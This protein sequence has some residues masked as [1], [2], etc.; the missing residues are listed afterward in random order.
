[1]MRLF[2]KLIISSSIASKR[3]RSKMGILFCGSLA[4]AVH[5]RPPQ[6]GF[7]KG[8]GIDHIQACTIQTMQAQEQ[9]CGSFL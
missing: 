5:D 2:K 6:A 9:I 7:R 4:Q 1:M 3:A 8:F